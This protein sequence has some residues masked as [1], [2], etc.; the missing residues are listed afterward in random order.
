MDGLQKLMST[1]RPFLTDGGFETWM[2]FI[3]GFEVP[4][5]AAIILMNDDKARQKMRTYFDRFLALAEAAK[6]GYVLDTNTWRGCIGWSSKLGVSEQEILSLSKDAVEFARDIQTSW[7]SRVAP[8]LIN[9]VV[10]PAGDGYS[11]EQSISAEQAE[12]M[13]QPQV[14]VFAG[15]NV[16][17]ISAI[18]MT[19]APEAI[20]ITRTAKKH[21]L[22]CVISF[23]VETDG[24]LPSGQSLAEAIHETD[25]ATDSAPLYYM[26]NCAH[27]E[28]FTEIINQDNSWIGR[29]GGL[30]ANASRMSH[31]ELDE[32]ETLDD[33]NP[34]EFGVLHRELADV[35]PSLRVIGGCCGTDHRH[36]GEVSQHLHR[37]A[38]I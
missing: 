14:D 16:D 22:P 33:G 38:D 4:E 31:A 9:G 19:N 23:T 3:E 27:P 35:L 18:T 29:I 20:G 12:E 36:V 37:N 5:F 17:M 1:K 21:H 7:A 25:S 24:R 10:G 13:H 32:S 26:I 28:H 15:S 34:D 11:I 2:F 6:T 30:R 8:V